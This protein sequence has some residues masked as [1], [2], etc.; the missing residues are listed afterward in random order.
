MVGERVCSFLVFFEGGEEK[1]EGGK[2]CPVVVV[3]GELKEKPTE[4]D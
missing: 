2:R 4:V 1:G 3:D